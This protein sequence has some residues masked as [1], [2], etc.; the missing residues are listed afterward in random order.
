MTI[1][2]TQQKAVDAMKVKYSEH[3]IETECVNVLKIGPT[4]AKFKG[5]NVG[6]AIDLECK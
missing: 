3:M 2:E 6:W 1:Y 5:C 4:I